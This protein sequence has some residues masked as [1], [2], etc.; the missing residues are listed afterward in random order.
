MVLAIIRVLHTSHTGISCFFLTVCVIKQLLWFEK[1]HLFE[2]YFACNFAREYVKRFVFF[3]L[4]IY[5]LFFSCRVLSCYLAT[6]CSMRFRRNVPSNGS[7]RHSILKYERTYI[8][9][10]L[11]F[12][13]YLDHKFK[14]QYSHLIVCKSIHDNL[15]SLK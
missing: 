8:Q 2:G 9:I 14:F 13:S 7:V 5:S 12:S 6:C 10:R 11:C 4:K 1:Y 15:I 3:S